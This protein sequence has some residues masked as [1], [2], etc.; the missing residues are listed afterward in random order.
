MSLLRDFSGA[1]AVS[2]GGVGFGVGAVVCI[3]CWGVWTRTIIFFLF[4]VWI[5]MVVS[6]FL[7]LVADATRCFISAFHGKDLSRPR[8]TVSAAWLSPLAVGV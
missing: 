6:S 8:Y 7:F 1:C 5:L 3:V 4:L 2:G